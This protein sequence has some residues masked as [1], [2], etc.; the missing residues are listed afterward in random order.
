MDN[1]YYNYDCPP[2]MNDGR[3]ISSYI[4]SNVFDQYIRTTNNI[5]S[6]QD[7]KNFLQNNGDKVLNNL[8]S[9]IRENNTCRIEGRCLPMA[10]PKTNDVVNYLNNNKVN[11]NFIYQY[12]NDQN[13]NLLEIDDTNLYETTTYNNLNIENTS[14][15]Q[16]YAQNTLKNTFAKSVYKEQQKNNL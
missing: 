1:R 10:E 12:T 8:K 5:Q 7:Y 15:D 16:E 13:N 9:H 4:R 2:L 3:F 6:A 11:D 14:F